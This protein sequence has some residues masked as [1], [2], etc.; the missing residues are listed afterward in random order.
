MR[1]SPPFALLVR[2]AACKKLHGCLLAHHCCAPQR[3][4]RYREIL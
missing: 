2:P 3:L 1:S 4:L